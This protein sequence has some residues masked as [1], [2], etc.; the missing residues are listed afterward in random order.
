MITSHHNGHQIY[1]DGKHW[2]FVDDNSSLKERNCHECSR[3]TEN[4]M[5]TISADLSHTGKTII[6]DKPI[7][8]CIASI[9]RALERGNVLMRSSCCGHG[10][11][12]GE[13][14]LQ[15]GRKIIIES[16]VS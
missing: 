16:P 4:V 15:D 3:A 1:W 11:W 14:I 10:K 9:V 13:I 6:R 8:K 12:S 2:K 5:V 7:D